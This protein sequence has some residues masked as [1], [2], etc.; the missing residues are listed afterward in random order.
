[1][2][3]ELKDFKTDK[4]DK[5]KKRIAEKFIRRKEKQEGE[6]LKQIHKVSSFLLSY[7]GFL[8]GGSLPWSIIQIAMSL[9]FMRSQNP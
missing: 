1:M 9:I 2:N 3:Q 8:L 4:N 6:E 7:L 5:I